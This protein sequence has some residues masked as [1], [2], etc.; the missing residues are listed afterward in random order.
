MKFL[1]ESK[2]RAHIKSHDKVECQLCGKAFKSKTVLKCHKFKHHNEKQTVKRIWK[3]ALCPYS[4]TTDRGL[5]YHKALVHKEHE[6]QINLVEEQLEDSEGSS[7]A[8]IDVCDEAEEMVQIDQSNVIEDIVV[9][10]IVL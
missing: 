4:V 6:E 2:L 5:R 9:E 10:N 3:C 7:E 8:N 1:T